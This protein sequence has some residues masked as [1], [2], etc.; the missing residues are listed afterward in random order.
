MPPVIFALNKPVDTTTPVVEAL[1]DKVTPGTE[2][3][4]QLVVID[5]AGHESQP[6]TV[7]VDVRDLLVGKIAP[8][9]P[10]SPEP[11]P[12][13]PAPKPPAP[14]PPAPKPPAPKPPAPKPPAPKPPAPKPSAPKPSAPKPT[15]SK[16]G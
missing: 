11:P 15:R 8:P 3:R 6:V 9:K 2:Y 13:P 5:Q 7:A 4:F 1:I 10:P 14:K 16:K 12:K